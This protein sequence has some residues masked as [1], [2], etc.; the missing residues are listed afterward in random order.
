MPSNV[1]FQPVYGTDGGRM[2]DWVL[3]DRLDVRV[4]VQEHKVLFGDTPGRSGPRRLL[5]PLIAA[6]RPR[7]V[8]MPNEVAVASLG[9]RPHFPVREGPVDGLSR[10]ASSPATGS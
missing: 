7:A 5:D 6:P 10:G 8:A 9:H 1:V 2:A 3:A 4:M